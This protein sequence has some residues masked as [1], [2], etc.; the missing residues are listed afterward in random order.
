M[1]DYFSNF[2][3][4]I[5]TLLYYPFITI[6]MWLFYEESHLLESYSIK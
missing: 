3:N 4:D 2:G 1:L 6:T 5:I